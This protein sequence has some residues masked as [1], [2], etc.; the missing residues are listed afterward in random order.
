MLCSKCFK[1]KPTPVTFKEKPYCIACAAGI[2]DEEHERELQ[3]I[4]IR[5]RIV[6]TTKELKDVEPKI[7]AA[8]VEKEAMEKRLVELHE[9][10]DSKSALLC[11]RMH[12]L[13]KLEAELKGFEADSQKTTAFGV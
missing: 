6:E 12:R 4:N 5:E 8:L 7:A 2:L 10:I 13:D 1:D 9:E 3:V 11:Y